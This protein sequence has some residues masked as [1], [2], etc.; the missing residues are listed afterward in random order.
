M[1][2]HLIQESK[3]ILKSFDLK[4]LEKAG[5]KRRKE[6]FELSHTIVTYPPFQTCKEIKPEEIFTTNKK[7]KRGVALYIHIP[8]CI[9]KCL[10]C[11][12]I[13]F[14]NQPISITEYYLNLVKKELELLL[15]IPELQD[16]IIKSIHV[17]GGT[18]T[19]LT[20][21]QL[22]GLM[23]FLNQ[24]LNIEKEAE[25]TFESCPETLIT[26]DGDKKLRKLLEKGV[27]RLSIGV[28]SFDDKVL[29][30]AGRSHNAKEAITAF[31]LARATGFKNINIDLMIG[32]P[33]Q[34]LENWNETLSQ[35]K[36]L[37]PESITA[38]HLRLKPIAPMFHLFQKQ[39]ERFPSDQ[40]DL[41][42]NIMIREKLS[43]LGYKENPAS[44]FNKEPKYIYKHQRQKWQYEAELLAIGVSSYSFIN[45]I[46]YYNYSDLKNYFSNLEYGKLPIWKGF[47][48]NKKEQIARKI[49]FGLKMVEGIEKEKYYNFDEEKFNKLK[50]V[51][52][53]EINKNIKLVWPKG[54]IF[55]EEICSQFYTEEIKKLLEK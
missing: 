27:N 9:T 20:I 17:G 12:Y 23:D 36:E 3:E 32:L 16:M 29:K 30:T 35:T 28:Q 4:E 37:M 39:L 40:D 19:Y 21:N 38:Y 11:H 15:K 46:Q 53:L 18:P 50:D 31:K 44:W 52:L 6:S 8:F 34:T 49:I 1:S 55:S 24:K 2:D 14:P 5:I 42:M 33:D 41:L 54:F 43:K 7:I 48:L 13:T 26:K 51:G 25:I 45:N 47:K 10:Y 22:A